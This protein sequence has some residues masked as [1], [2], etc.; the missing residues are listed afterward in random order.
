M[1]SPAIAFPH[2]DDPDFLAELGG[3]FM[4]CK[5][6]FAGAQVGLFEKLKDGPLTSDELAK[7]TGL[8]QR[9]VH[10]LVSGL[11]AMG[12]LELKDGKLSNG[13]AAQKRL[14]SRG[15]DDIRPGFRLYDLV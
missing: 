2:P 14:T 3:L 11:V 8:P 7:A 15:S 4:G 5:M 13:K 12:V 10:V 9:S 6:L 1:P